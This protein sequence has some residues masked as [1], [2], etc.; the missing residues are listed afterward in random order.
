MMPGGSE[1]S[2]SEEAQLE[3]LDVAVWCGGA[4]KPRDVIG[5]RS[6]ARLRHSPRVSV[7][8]KFDSPAFTHTISSPASFLDEVMHLSGISGKC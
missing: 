2:K 3:D 8:G 4:A 6:F 5:R 7:R 1:S